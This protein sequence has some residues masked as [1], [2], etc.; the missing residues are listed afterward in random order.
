MS[1][2]IGPIDDVHVSISAPDGTTFTP[3]RP[4]GFYRDFLEEFEQQ[5]DLPSAEEYFAQELNT[6]LAIV[7]SVYLDGAFVEA[8]GPS[9]DFFKWG[10]IGDDIGY[11][12][13]GAFILGFDR[14]IADQLAE[15]EAIIDR[16]LA[17][18]SATQALIID[19]RLSPGGADPIA[20]AV[21]N[22]F[23]DRERVAI[24]K[25]TRATGSPGLVEEVSVMPSAR[26]RY[27]NP[28]VVLTSG[29]SASATETFILAMR[30]L[31]QVRFVGERTVGALSDIL[32]KPLPNGWQVNLANEVYF[33]AAG[34]AYEA[35]GIPPDIEVPAFGSRERRIGQDSALNAALKQLGGRYGINTVW[36]GWCTDVPSMSSKRVDVVIQQQVSFVQ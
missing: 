33:D 11:L 35:V 14:P 2:L 32:E 22:R 16:V 30:A 5:T 24:R 6:A 8:G 34:I 15:V 28:A 17:D 31:P 4:K 1:E 3:G 29:F 25:T 36:P 18:L 27:R 12:N 10:L 23:A 20:L 26:I 7:D 13:V 21:A 19:V 9:D